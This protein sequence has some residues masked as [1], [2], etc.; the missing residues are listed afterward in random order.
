[1]NEQFSAFLDNEATRDEAD[2]VINS[3]LRDEALRDSWSRQYRIR[4][5]LS[6]PAGES[7]AAA[8]SGFCERVMQAVRDDH[9]RLVIRAAERLPDAANTANDTQPQDDE[10]AAAVPMPRAGQ[11]RL[12]RTVTGLAVAAS[13]AG[14]A[15]FVTQ[16]LSL[17]SDGAATSADTPAAAQATRMAAAQPAAGTSEAEPASAG[18]LQLQMAASLAGDMIASA[19]AFGQS[20]QDAVDHWEVSNSVLANRLNSYLVE[21]SGL[22]RGYGLGPTS[23]G[24]VRVATYGQGSLP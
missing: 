10:S 24:F 16:P 2:A 7:T 13:A 6:A 22:A 9:P 19:A 18:G 11:H 15:L 17:L 21:H 3:L 8:D 12:R 4:E 14:F 23:P 5:I 20:S 1:M